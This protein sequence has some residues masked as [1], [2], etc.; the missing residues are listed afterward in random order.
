M[1]MIWMLGLVTLVGCGGNAE[2]G[3]AGGG[4][5]GGS[6]GAAGSAGSGG[7]TAGM[8]GTGGTDTGNTIWPHDAVQLHAT[9]S[10]GGEM[11]APPPGSNCTLGAADY[12]LDVT[13][14]SLAWTECRSNATWEDPWLETKG[15]VTLSDDEYATVDAAMLGLTLYAGNSCGADKPMLVVEVT[16]P[17][18]TLA[19]YDSFYSCSADDRVYVE[20][21][22]AVFAALRNVTATP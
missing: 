12:A 10:G 15:T 14:R 16:N 4:G 5:S 6:A 7:G 11:P 19:Y 21:I 20:N 3:A 2:E 9:S 1:R 13:S 18:G 8:G 17:N 22:D